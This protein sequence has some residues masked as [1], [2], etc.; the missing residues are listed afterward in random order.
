[1]ILQPLNI[2]TMRKLLFLL[3][4]FI[5][6]G[7][8]LAQE[9]DKSYM[10]WETMIVT[11][12]YTKLSAF[13][14]AMAHHNKTY[15]NTAPYTANVYNISTGPNMGKLMWIMG[16][17]TYT[18]L[19]S[20]PSEGGHDEDWATN[21]MPL[22]KEMSNGEFWKMNADLSNISPTGGPYKIQRVRFHE[23]AKG[24]G[25]RMNG[26]LK[27]VSETVKAMEG[28]N[29][30]G[31]FYNEWQQ[32]FKIGRHV[33]T[34]SYHNSWSELDDDRS[35]RKTFEKTHGENSWSGFLTEMQDVFSN[36]WDEFWV[37]ND[38]MSADVG[39]EE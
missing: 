28:D 6:P 32:G 1:M 21:V 13:S 24:Q 12:D 38:K 19:D 34:V 2:I 23:V 33:A 36:S 30:W 14:D 7:L 20:R 5:L 4:G 15:H 29:P 11:P 31:V 8:L 16:P 10:M 27:K 25:Y 39:G 37:R 22:I 18:H 35:F 17:C 3:I 9:E 26:L